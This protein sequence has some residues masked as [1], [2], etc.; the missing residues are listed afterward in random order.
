MR[1]AT[2]GGDEGAAPRLLICAANRVHRVVKLHPCDESWLQRPA[3]HSRCKLRPSPAK[4]HA[5]QAMQ[6]GRVSLLA[7]SSRRCSPWS[8]MTLHRPYLL[9]SSMLITRLARAQTLQLQQLARFCNN[10]CPSPPSTGSALVQ[11]LYFPSR[12][13]ARAHQLPLCRLP[14]TAFPPLTPALAFAA[15]RRCCHNDL[16][17]RSSDFAAGQ[18]FC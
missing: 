9:E 10:P 13:Y 17:K 12:I 2:T 11:S 4:S 15:R 18:C 3:V 7:T 6:L 16:E 14:H 8:A 1:S 5:S